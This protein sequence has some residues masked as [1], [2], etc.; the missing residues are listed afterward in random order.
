MSLERQI[1]VIPPEIYSYAVTLLGRLSRGL[2]GVMDQNTLL[3]YLSCCSRCILGSTSE[4]SALEVM[5]FHLKD[6]Y[7]HLWKKSGKI[8]SLFPQSMELKKVTLT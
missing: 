3:D 6:G 4:N 5:D 1:C 2:G 8:S 7:V